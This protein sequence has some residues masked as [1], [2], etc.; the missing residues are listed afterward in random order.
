MEQRQKH[1][2]LADPIGG[3][4]AREVTEMTSFPHDRDTLHK[5]DLF[6]ACFADAA[7]GLSIT[8][9]QGR[10]LDLNP[11]YCA[12][13]G[14]SKAELWDLNFQ[15]ITH[16]DDLP[17]TL[18]NIGSLIAGEIPLFVME[19]RYMR[20]GGVVVWVENT[21]SLIRG[22]DERP[23]NLVWI[24]QDISARKQLEAELSKAKEFSETLIQTANTIILGLD[25]D[26]KI[27]IL[28]RAAEEITGYSLLELKEKNWFETLVPKERYPDV[29]QGFSQLVTGGANKT[30]ENPILTKSGQERHILWHNNQVAVDGKVVAIISFGTDVTER[31]AAEEAL[32]IAEQRYRDIFENAGEG[33]FQTTPEGQYIAANPALARIHGFDSPEELISSLR[34]ISRE[35]YVDPTR[36]DE[37]KRLLEKDGIV[38]GFEHQIFRH[39]GTRIWI[40]VN[41]RGVRDER[42]RILYYEGTTQ[43][44]TERKRAE[45]SLRASEERYRKLAENFPNGAV[46]TYDR[47]LRVTFM[48]GGSLRENGF[49]P[50]S[51]VGK[52]LEEIT[53]PDVVAEVTP[54]LRSAFAGRIEIY[55]AALPNGRT[56]LSTVAPLL[57]ENG[58]INEILV[59][60]QNITERKQAQEEL[61]ESEERYKDL[62]ENSRELIC[63][64]DLNGV[65]LSANPAAAAAVGYELDELVGQKNV[66]EILAPEV[67]HQFDEYMARLCRDGATSGHML[68]ST[69][70]GERRVWEYYNSLRTEGVAVPIVRGIA[71][72]ITDRKRTEDALRESESF[73]R[74]IVASEPECVKLVAPDFTIVDMNPAGLSMMGAVSKEQVVGKPMLPLIA[75]EWR[76]TFKQMHERVCQG[77]S[78]IAE[79]EIIGLTG[80]R[81]WMET[82]AAPLRNSESIVIGQL[83][84]TRDITERKRADESL[85]LFRNLIDQSNDAIEVIDPITFRF[86]DCNQSAYRS[87][88]YSREE[89]LSLTVFDIDPLIDRSTIARLDEQLGESNAATLESLHR[90][91]DGTTFPVEINV[92][93]VRLERDYRLA[94]VRDITGR[95][96]AEEALRES[97]ERYRELF[98]N[99]KDAIYVHDLGGRY[100]SV[101]RA[102]EQL[103][104]FT[105]EEIL[106]KHFSNFVSPRDLK[107]VRTNLCRKLDEE[108]ETI[109]DV[110]LVT[111]TGQ[112]VPVEVSSRLI[113]ENGVAVGVQGTARDITDRKRA[114]EALRIYSQRLIQAQEAEREKIARELHD[115]IGQVLTAVRINLQSIQRSRGANENARPLTKA[116]ALSMKRWAACAS[117][118]SSC[119]HRCSTTWV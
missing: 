97:E 13:T 61:R 48:A 24:S 98:E 49:S 100:T 5:S 84:I 70:S 95:K 114:Q 41:A 11:A 46:I 57:D 58:L 20:K 9:L 91:K 63:T 105:R 102:A 26:G 6:R 108:N 45:Q 85:Q 44:I 36:R 10:F 42:G 86:I 4:P 54:H 25:T 67:R 78:V 80:V 76:D 32:R 65:V 19:D 92:K 73:R 104:G 34:D 110:D 66:R 77:E 112:R 106:G 113:Y 40:S 103:S 16:P 47:D 69:K 14:Y 43:D 33:I 119:V 109:Y 1:S 60:S 15:A 72:D 81:R 38:R 117:F 8:D 118:R 115:E 83:A 111:R 2:G 30:F 94:V 93:L 96:S 88:G 35:V 7:L 56:Y 28:N 37:F 89:F 21:V 101:N 39:D 50:D 107:Q 68:V 74:A 59:I 55:E 64:H 75:P 87:L 18:A 79:F 52:S 17:G 53:S 62:I 27:K 29:W 3:A 31:K 71:R 51:F 116:S 22:E 90:R 99:A 82:H 23:L 12:I